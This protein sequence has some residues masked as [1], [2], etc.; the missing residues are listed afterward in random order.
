MSYCGSNPPY[1]ISAYGL[2][3]KMGFEGTVEEWLDSLTAFYMAKKAGY[4]GTSEDWV[5]KLVDPLPDITIGEVVTLEGG[6]MATVVITGTK[7]HPVLNF[8][9]PRGVGMADALPLV[10][11]RMKGIIDMDGNGI[12]NLP[13]PMNNKDPVTKNYADKIKEDLSKALLEACKKLLSLS[14]GIMTGDINM[15][16][17]SISNVKTPEQ[18]SEAANKKY[19]DDA[20]AAAGKY[21]DSKHLSVTATLSTA[22]TGDAAPYKQTVTIAGILATDHPHVMPV[23]SD[24]LDTAILEKEAWALVSDADTADGSITFTCFEEKPVTAINVQ[25][26][27]NR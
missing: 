16:G 14:G 2:A 22:W 9:I 27:V 25:I 24:A 4:A 3:R 12:T 26:E 10:G 17:K 23:Y 5:K 19:V 21:T 8:G 18:D 7:E 11:G 20:K 6:S 1:Y 13:D 15:N